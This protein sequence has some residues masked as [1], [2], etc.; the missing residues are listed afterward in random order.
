MRILNAVEKKP[1]DSILE[2]RLFDNLQ[3]AVCFTP[4]RLL[5]EICLS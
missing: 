5:L 2:N 4:L 3:K 1:G